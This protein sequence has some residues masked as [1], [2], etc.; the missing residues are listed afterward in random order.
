VLMNPVLMNPVLM[1]PL[2]DGKDF[3]SSYRIIGKR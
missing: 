3:K 1:N 2:S